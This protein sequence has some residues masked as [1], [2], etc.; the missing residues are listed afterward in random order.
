MHIQ[1]LAGAWQFRQ[2]GDKEWLPATVPGGVH[3]DLL[4]L[5]KIPDPFVADNEKKVAWVAEQDW[6]YRYQFTANADVL[7]E[8]KV[9]LV[10]DGLDTLAEV[11]INGQLVGAANNMFRRYTW[12]VR[13]LLSEGNNE[14]MIKFR[15]PVRFITTENAKRPLRGVTQAIAGGPHLRKAPCQFGWDWGPQLPPIGVWKDIRLEGRS[16]ARLED[17]HLRQKHSERSVA[18]SATV[19]VERWNDAPVTAILRLTA[20]DHS[21][22]QEV[23]EPVHSKYA[24]LVM[25]VD[26]PQLWWPNDYGSQPLYGVEVLLEQNGVRVD[27]Q[28][29][30]LGLRTVEL[31]QTP[32]QWGKSFTFVVNGVPIFA[33]GSNWIPADS[34]PT[35]LAGDAGPGASLEQLIRDA[36]AVHQNM[37]RVWGGG[38]YE[39]ERFYDLCDRYGILVWQDCIFSCSIYPLNRADFVD[40]VRQEI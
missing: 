36:A 6:E 16:G 11:M 13:H 14:L 30:Q 22:V 19:A 12:D 7:T 28:Y 4:A 10:C 5:G 25:A 21:S 38:F 20:P 2:A 33:K 35:R 26:N 23:I 40:D 17:V 3:T 32:D 34:F 29:F 27:A 24:T 8:E 39:E 9:F 1:S 31:R 37:L 15:S 18:V